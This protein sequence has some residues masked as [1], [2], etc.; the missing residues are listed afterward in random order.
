MSSEAPDPLQH[1]GAALFRP[2]GVDGVY[3]R[4]ALYEDLVERLTAFISRQPAR[5]PKSSMGLSS[6]GRSRISGLQ[7]DKSMRTPRMNPHPDPLPA[8][9]ERG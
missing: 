8:H 1:I 3:A 5:V 4:T 2:L 6:S 7:L 9:R